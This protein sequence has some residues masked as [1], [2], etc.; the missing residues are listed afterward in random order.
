MQKTITSPL[1][2]QFNHIGH[3]FFTRDGGISEGDYAGLNCNEASQDNPLRVTTNH[4][5]ALSHLGLSISQ[6]ASYQAQHGNVAVTA[7]SPGKPY[8]K[9]DAIVTNH[10]QLVLGA[11]S[12][13]CPTVLMVDPINRVLGLAHAGWRSALSGILEN[14]LYTMCQQGATE[15]FIH[16][17]IGPGIAKASYQ[18][19]HPFYQQ[20]YETNPQYCAHFEPCTQPLHWRFDLKGFI[21]ERLK[22]LGVAHIDD[23]GLDT[24]TNEALFYSCRR[25]L[26]QGRP[27]FGGHLACLYFK[28]AGQAL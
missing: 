7:T 28:D 4:T 1:L 13:D 23:V 11:D 24:Y 25:A 8:P 9:A 21:N 12:A 17:V 16:A 6:L 18:V 5:L 19:S 2:E 22:A 10:A 27:D 14:T 15:R 20:F 26:H 3:A